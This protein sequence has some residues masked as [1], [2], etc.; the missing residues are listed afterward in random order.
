MAQDAMEPSSKRKN[1]PRVPEKSQNFG[2]V[3]D[4]LKRRMLSRLFA[5]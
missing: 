5:Y 2:E 4:I 1:S 3:E